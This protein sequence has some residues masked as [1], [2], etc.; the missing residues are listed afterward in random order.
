MSSI[1]TDHRLRMARVG[2]QLTMQMANRGIPVQ[3]AG[4][5]AGLTTAKVLSVVTGQPDITILE[6]A[7]FAAAIGCRVD[8]NIASAEP[9]A[10]ATSHAPSS[11]SPEASGESETPSAPPG[12]SASLL[13]IPITP[14]NLT[15]LKDR[16]AAES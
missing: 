14:A 6:V 8:I 13:G 10:A 2:A 11:A 15:I 9:A 3:D 12:K 1:E 4:Q 5:R 7:T 16:V